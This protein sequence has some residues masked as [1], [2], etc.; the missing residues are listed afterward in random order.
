MTPGEDASGGQEGAD[1]PTKEGP[2]PARG[3]CSWLPVSGGNL[4]RC[5]GSGGGSGS[6]HRLWVI[7]GQETQ[8]IEQL[9]IIPP[10]YREVGDAS[11]GGCVLHCLHFHLCQLLPKCPPTSHSWLHGRALKNTDWS[12][13]HYS[14]PVI[15][16]SCQSYPGYP[17]FSVPPVRC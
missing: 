8:T 15:H 12:P 5:R 16:V 3:K 10:L 1:S 11:L 13:D 6:L 2:A 7:G 4:F 14:V 17:V 9:S